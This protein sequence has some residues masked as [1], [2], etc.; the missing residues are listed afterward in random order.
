[1]PNP[2]MLNRPF[3]E[4][5]MRSAALVTAA[6][7]A[8]WVTPTRAVNKCVEDTGKVVYQS[9]PCPTTSQGSEMTLQ[10]AAPAAV[11]SPADADELKRIQQTAGAM[12]R[13]R[14]LKEINRDIGRAE[15]LIASY[16]Q[17]MS[18]E[19][20]ALQQKKQRANNN[21]A[22]A[23]WEQSISAEMSAVSQKYDALIRT[24]QTRIERLRADAD[25]LRK[26]E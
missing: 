11:V 8:F 20:N 6:L 5:I 2:P 14:K 17:S 1:M 24:E 4:V 26:L 23:T 21:L 12:E 16:R 7:L 19:L 15:D 18:N 10:K 13:E 3:H 25:R 9:A 22:G